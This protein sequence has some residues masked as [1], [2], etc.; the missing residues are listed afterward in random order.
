MYN[1]G[2][3]RTDCQ[4]RAPYY[5]CTAPAPCVKLKMLTFFLSVGPDFNYWYYF[6]AMR[7]LAMIQ[8]PVQ[9]TPHA[10]KPKR[11]AGL[12]VLCQRYNFGC[13][14]LDSPNFD[15]KGVADAFMFFHLS[16]HVVPRLFVVKIS[17]TAAQ[18]VR[19]V[20]CPPRPAMTTHALCR[21]SRRYPQSPGRT[22]RWGMS[23]VTPA[24][25]VL[26]TPPAARPQQETGPAVLYLR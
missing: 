20:T 18:K 12:A 19:N 5:T 7:S 24:T 1:G 26:M 22:H 9:M 13:V 17:F 6:Q 15:F 21:G 2:V 16:D 11:A 3:T 8:Q 25:V 23:H 14:F 10:V 4:D